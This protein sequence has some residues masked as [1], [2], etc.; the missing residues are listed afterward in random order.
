[1]RSWTIYTVLA[2]VSFAM[3]FYGVYQICPPVSWIT[4]GSLLWI[5]LFLMGRIK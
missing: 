5:D 2:C 4:V 1:M 3:I